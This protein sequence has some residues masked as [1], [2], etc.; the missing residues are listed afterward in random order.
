MTE[1]L[2]N[3]CSNV[4]NNIKVKKESETMD[5]EKI[6]ELVKDLV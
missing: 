4:L 6:I 2:G 1:K 5:R 3:I